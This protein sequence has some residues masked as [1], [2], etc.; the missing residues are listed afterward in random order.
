MQTPQPL[1]FLS[2][3]SLLTFH[4]C[5]KKWQLDKLGAANARFS[6]V[7]FSFGHALG[8]GIQT[9]LCG[10]TEEDAIW[11][12]FKQWDVGLYDEEIKTKKSFAYVVVGI[13][14]FVPFAQSILQDWE[15]AVFN[16][17]PAV[18]LSYKLDLMNGFFYRAHID[19]VL[20]HRTEGKLMVVE[21]KSTG[22][23]NVMEATY[24]NSDQALSYAIALDKIAAGNTAYDVLYMVYKT[25]SQEYEPLSFSKSMLDKARWI[26]GVLLDCSHGQDY[27]SDNFFPMRGESCVSYYRPCQ[28]YGMCDM[29]DKALL[30]SQSELEERVEKELEI[31]YTFQFTLQD[32]IDQQLQT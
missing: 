4:E 22:F 27:I 18:E 30:A 15:I 8:A 6:T 26:K 2:Y 13:Q 11:E 1:H 32:I 20:K 21:L 23:D 31:S 16:D 19:V 5:P 3:S 7:T 24:G 14:K 17:K 10:R 29:S 9:L 12:A 28:Y 25:K